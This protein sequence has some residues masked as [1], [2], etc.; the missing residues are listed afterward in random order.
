MILRRLVHLVVV[1]FFVT[2]FVALLTAMLPA[3]RSTP[4]PGSP[5]PSRRT[6]CART[7]ASTTRCLCAYGRWIGDFV[8]G[9]LGNYYSVTGER[10]VMDRVP[11][12]CPCRCSS[13]CTPRCWRWSSPSRRA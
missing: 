11:T 12:R 13:C 4:S 5:A 10:P 9:D 2:L 3:T 7:S 1:L 6:R 8:T